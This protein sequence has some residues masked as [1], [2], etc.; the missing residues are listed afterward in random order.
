MHLCFG[1]F[2]RVLLLWFISV[3]CRYFFIISA[4]YTMLTF[5]LLDSGRVSTFIIIIAVIIGFLGSIIII[6]V[7]GSCLS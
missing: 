2:L 4:I 5:A 1:F 3:S 7:L 6:V